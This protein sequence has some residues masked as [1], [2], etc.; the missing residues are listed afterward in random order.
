MGCEV[1][2]TPDGSL[3]L[4]NV[5]PARYLVKASALPGRA[6]FEKEEYTISPVKSPGSLLRA[7]GWQSVALIAE[8]QGE[9]V[10]A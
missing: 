2:P 1:S 3:V 6:I 7:I 8:A 5:L 10:S 4:R 9:K